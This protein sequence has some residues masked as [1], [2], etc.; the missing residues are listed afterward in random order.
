MTHAPAYGT[1]RLALVPDLADIPAIDIFDP[2]TVVSLVRPQGLATRH[3]QPGNGESTSHHLSVNNARDCGGGNTR[4]LGESQSG[5]KVSTRG[6]SQHV[7]GEVLQFTQDGIGDMPVGPGRHDTA[8]SVS[9]QRGGHGAPSSLK[10]EPDATAQA[11]STFVDTLVERGILTSTNPR[12]LTIHA[13]TIIRYLTWVTSF[14]HMPTDIATLTDLVTDANTMRD[15]L[16]F[17]AHRYSPATLNTL[18][19]TLAS[20]HRACEHA[21]GPTG[22]PQEPL[23]LPHPTVRSNRQPYTA[24]DLIRLNDWLN[25]RPRAISTFHAHVITALA[26]GAGLTSQ[27]IFHTRYADITHHGPITAVTTRGA[28]GT[29]PRTIPIT[30]PYDDMLTH[31]LDTASPA[32]E[33]EHVVRPHSVKRVPGYADPYRLISDTICDRTR[34]TMFVPRIA[35]LRYTWICHHA[36]HRVDYTNLRHATGATQSFDASFKRMILNSHIFTPEEY[37]TW[38]K[39]TPPDKPTY[40]PLRLA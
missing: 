20:C 13:N 7:A 21:F 3:L 30:H 31:A 6:L 34:S 22:I 14:H 26:L 19:Y 2:V 8:R 29:T 28:R 18:Y 23:S 39:A 17:N 1:S 12:A 27:E 36:A 9:R 15:Y 10:D 38:A 16:N 11:V 35:R 24:S 32:D 40:P 4:S 5:A 33:T 37:I 25:S